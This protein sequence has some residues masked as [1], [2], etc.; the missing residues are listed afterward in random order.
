MNICV[1]C[2]YIHAKFKVTTWFDT[3]KCDH[4]IFQLI[5]YLYL[6]FMYLIVFDVVCTMMLP[7][8]LVLFKVR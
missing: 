7:I 5:S 3:M 4:N 6:D 2:V 8:L 1:Y